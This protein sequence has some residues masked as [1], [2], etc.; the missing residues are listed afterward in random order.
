MT[1]V[2]SGGGIGDLKRLQ[3]STITMTRFRTKKFQKIDLLAETGRSRSLG[4]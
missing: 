1:I 2:T 4:P 3:P